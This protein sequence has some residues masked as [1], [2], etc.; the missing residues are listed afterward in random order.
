MATC[1]GKTDQPRLPL[2]YYTPA[3]Y[4]P[5]IPLDQRVAPSQKATG[6]ER[7]VPCNNQ[8]VQPAELDAYTF[9]TEQFITSIGLNIYDG[10][11]WSIALA[12]L[13]E[14]EEV[15]AYERG[16]T[17]GG[18]TC[19]FKDIRGDKQCEGV[20]VQ[21]QCQDPDQSGVCG[22]CYGESTTEPF[23]TA[24]TFRGISDYW[25]LEHTVDQRC[26]ELGHTWIWNDYKP[27]L[28]EN[29]WAN[30]IGPL[31][32][33]YLK[34]GGIASIPV[35]DMSL[36]LALNFLK[37]LPAMVEPTSQGL[38]Y[39]PKNTLLN[40]T[41]DLGF[42]IS[43]ENNVSLLGGLKMLRYI[44]QTRNIY[45]NFLPIVV[46]LIGNCET[47]IKAAYDASLG[48]FRQ[49]GTVVNNVFQWNTEFAVD[50]Q[51][52]TM[53]QLGP[54][55]VDS[56][57]G[58]G[59]AAGIWNTTKKIGGYHFT[60]WSG[61]I[62]GLGFSENSNDQVFSGEWTG[63]GVNMLRIFASELIDPSY[64]KEAEHIRNQIEYD[65]T[66]SNTIAGQ[67]VK[68]VRYANKRYFIPFGWW[69]NP[70]DATAATTWA[71]FLDSNFNPLHLGGAYNSSY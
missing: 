56:W 38:Y 36:Q 67:P 51:T 55:R 20:I 42:T 47:F 64:M 69:A 66:E 7:V 30:I 60:V 34:Y 23:A 3:E 63:G 39:S 35:D 57:F 40:P 71:V 29:A 48:Y 10:A 9:E 33:A 46:Q 62:D 17:L 5:G 6:P 4:Y 28:G 53:S 68:A 1:P 12:I 18:A 25:S 49:G 26:P 24:W 52:W 61:Q 32:V 41:T 15:R 65:L 44:L 50:C 58:A 2:S 59:T 37:S 19:Q 27:V 54:K 70:L 8:I 31:Q 45:P 11:C 43:V 16:I 21:G 13:G 22:F 14:I